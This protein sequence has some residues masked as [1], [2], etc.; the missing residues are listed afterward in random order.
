LPDDPALPARPG[1]YLLSLRLEAPLSLRGRFAGT[2]L[3]PGRYAY[4]G[5]ARGPGGL[6]ARLARHLRADKKAHWHIDQLTAASRID[7]IGYAEDLDE[8]ALLT[9]AA[10]LAGAHA[11]VPGFG[12]S[13]CRRCTAHMVAVANPLAIP[14][15]W[16]VRGRDFQD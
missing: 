6:K 1:A 2:V 8:C 14:I 15:R 3:P 9:A 16:L 10:A 11:P 7:A 5:N 12:S 13:D 4:A